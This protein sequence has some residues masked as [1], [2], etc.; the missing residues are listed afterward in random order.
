[1][2]NLKKIFI[3]KFSLS[4]FYKHLGYRLFIALSLSMLVAILDSFGISLFL[5]LLQM[6]GGKE[7][8]NPEELG[9]LSYLING[10][11]TIGFDLT[12]FRVLVFMLIF[13]IS[14]G[15]VQFLTSTYKVS[16]QRDF[17]QNLRLN[18]LELFN[19]I[20]YKSFVNSDTGR[21]QNTLTTE[22]ERITQSYNF[23]LVTFQQGI[24]AL[25]YLIFSYFIDYKFAFFVTAGALLTNMFY[26]TLFKKTKK[27]SLNFTSESNAY[28]GLISQHLTNFKYL[29]ATGLL[30]KYADKIFRSVKNIE[31][32]RKNI[33]VYNTILGAVKE[34]V[35]ITMIV[36]IIILQIN[37]LEGN[38]GEILISLL[39]FYRALTSI[40]SVQYFWNQYVSTTGSIDNIVNLQQSFENA[41][42]PENQKY[43]DKTPITLELKNIDFY[44]E[45]TRIIKHVNLKILPYKTIAFVGESGSG[46]TTLLNIISGLLQVD[47]GAF[48]INGQ[49]SNAIDLLQYNKHIG[50]IAQEPVIFKD[51]LFNNVTFWDKKSE[52]T[53]EKFNKAITQASVLDFVESLDK[54]ENTLLGNDG[55]NL[56]GGQKQRIAIARELY[57]DIEI[58]IMD[59]ATSSLDS[60]TERNIQKHI[61]ALKGKYTILIAGHRLSTVKN[62][63]QIVFM[64]QAEIIHVGTFD[65]TRENVGD[66]KRMV[67]LQEL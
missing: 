9:K 59:E 58:L 25:V 10:I 33:G 5:P 42:A 35:L 14:K 46:K 38:I 62:A 65:E 53:I 64:K 48:L 40:A 47:K 24:M 8:I 15:V 36:T 23:Y 21:I 16:L 19:N 67:E 26:L 30:K 51:T 22:I 7:Q 49:N 31:A 13:F 11:K 6:A 1:M 45:K 27:A 56:S 29:K 50:Y 37:F 34:P 39:F 17:V 55:I 41:Q 28:H 54:R 61:D 20:N 44:Y 12:L 60:E 4:Y 63:D 52:R 57:K 66:F 32:S 3:N 43:E 2:L 18:M